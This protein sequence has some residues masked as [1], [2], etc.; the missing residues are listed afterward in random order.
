MPSFRSLRS[1]L[2]GLHRVVAEC[3]VSPRLNRETTADLQWRDGRGR[4]TEARGRCL[5]VSERGARVAYSEAITL[6]AVMQ[7]RP[8]GDGITRTGIVRHCTP[9]GTHYEIGVEFCSL[10]ELRGALK[11]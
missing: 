9:N 8:D 5:D 7:I 1:A 4:I 3:R 6:P 11:T 10:A 2:S